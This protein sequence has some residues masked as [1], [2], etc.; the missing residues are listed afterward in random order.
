M[1]SRLLPR[2]STAHHEKERA[3]WLSAL[4]ALVAD[5][6]TWS[7]ENDWGTR[8]D[9]KRLK[10]EKLGAYDAPVLLIQSPKGRWLLE[11]IARYVVGAEGRVDLCVYPSY[12]SVVIARE[13]DGSWRIVELGRKNRVRPWN[14]HEFTKI[15]LKIL[16]SP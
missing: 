16:E 5:V 7:H 8:R 12:D 6:E 1:P 13:Q 15:A 2:K 4:E 3:E 11:P 9:S 14:R 10:E